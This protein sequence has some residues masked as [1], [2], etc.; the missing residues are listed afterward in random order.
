[1]KLISFLSRFA[2]AGVAAFVLGIALDVQPL[3]FFS[4]AIGALVLLGVAGDYAP[5]VQDGPASQGN[6]I[7]FTPPA[8]ARVTAPAKLAA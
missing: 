4:F 8:P 7:D 2:L 1:M 6:V 5:R 3:A